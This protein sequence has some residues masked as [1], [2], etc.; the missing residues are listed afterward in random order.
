MVRYL[1]V[2]FAS[3][4]IA[5][6][7]QAQ[8]D[9]AAERAADAVHKGNQALREFGSK[10]REGTD[11]AANAAREGTRE[12]GATLSDAAIKARVKTAL[13]AEQSVD[14]SR[15]DVDAAAGVITLTGTVSDSQQV[16]RAGEIAQSIDGVKSVRNRL[17]RSS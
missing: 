14:G 2:I 15:I 1:C 11:K 7:D 6:C 3:F 8:E 4:A 9:R 16:H 13:L 5:A 12:L 10:A 17:S